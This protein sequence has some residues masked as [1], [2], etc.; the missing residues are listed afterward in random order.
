M[1]LLNLVLL[2]GLSKGL[3]EVHFGLGTAFDGTDYALMQWGNSLSIIFGGKCVAEYHVSIL[4]TARTKSA[5]APRCFRVVSLE[6]HGPG[7]LHI[8][9][10]VCEPEAAR[11]RTA[12]WVDERSAHLLRDTDVMY[13]ETFSD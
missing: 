5:C 4:G 8:V 7:V 11:V 2:F 3:P 1:R 12:R 6:T 10:G 9:N 13:F